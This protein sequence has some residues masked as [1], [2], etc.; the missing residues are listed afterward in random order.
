MHGIIRNNLSIFLES[1]SKKILRAHLLRLS[2]VS[3]IAENHSQQ[4]FYIQVI[5]FGNYVIVEM[6]TRLQ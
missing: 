6:Q 4:A 1:V 2:I 3:G 5:I